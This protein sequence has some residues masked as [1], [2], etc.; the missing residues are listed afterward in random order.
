MRCRSTSVMLMV[1]NHSMTKIEIVEDEESIKIQC[2]EICIVHSIDAR[3]GNYFI[4]PM[5]SQLILASD[6]HYGCI[7]YSATRNKN[8]VLPHE[9]AEPPKLANSNRAETQIDI[10]SI[11]K[12]KFVTITAPSLK[13]SIQIRFFV[14]LS[15]HFVFNAFWRR[16]MQGRSSKCCSQ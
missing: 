2:A 13:L 1:A 3:F 8:Q 16:Q 9:K 7:L 4:S 6:S 14:S 12:N 11:K 5:H 15:C 10:I